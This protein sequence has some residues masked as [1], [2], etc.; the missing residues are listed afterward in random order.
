MN[1][2]AAPTRLSPQRTVLDNGLTVII[3]ENPTADIVAAQ[4]FV[5]AGSIQDPLGQEG[6]SNLVAAMLT[7]GTQTAT[8]QQ[9]AAQVES[10]GVSL[11]ADSAPDYC[12]LS[13]KTVGADFA[14]MLPLVAELLRQPS[15]PA[16]EFLLEQKLCLQSIRARQEQPLSLALE[17]LRKRLYG[18][19]PY[20]QVGAGNAQSVENLTRDHLREFHHQYFHPT[21]TTISIAG[22][23]AP[24]AALKQVEKVFGDWDST[25][26]GISAQQPSPSST[27]PAPPPPTVQHSA[28]PK[29]TQQSTVMVGF[30]AP[31]V[32]AA[33]YPVLKLLSTY[34][35]SGLSSRLF[36]ELREKRGLAYEVSGFYPT[37]LDPSHFVVYLGTAPANTAIARDLLCQE[38]ARLAEQPLA[39]PDLANTKRKLMGQYALGKQTNQQIAHQ[40]G[41]YAHLGLGIEHDV[42]F[43]DQIRTTTAT[44]VQAAAD[45]WLTT[46]CISLVGPPAFLPEG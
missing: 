21:R 44:A 37:R 2:S 18:Q 26:P 25:Q 12:L 31:S 28:Y 42:L 34:L 29:P 24:A 19:H 4:F 45:Q 14:D 40:F 8:A 7:K 23:I 22:N 46:P 1:D 6:C 16:A 15:F 39:T 41:W 43:L 5:A 10:T 3:T 9:I 32:H 36:C 13:L 35:C 30:L 11:G 20:H 17:Q 27:Q 33:A 38:V